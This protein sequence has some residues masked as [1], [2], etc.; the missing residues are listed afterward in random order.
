[1]LVNLSIIAAAFGGFTLGWNLRSVCLQR[2][3][4]GNLGAQRLILNEGHT[5]RGNGHGGPLTEKS[6]ISASPQTGSRIA[7]S[8]EFARFMREQAQR[9]N[10]LHDNPQA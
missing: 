9:F 5:M 4:G 1:M 3:R 7:C 10:D 2:M 6:R 8:P